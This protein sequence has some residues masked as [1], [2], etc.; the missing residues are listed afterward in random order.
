MLINISH[1]HR[2]KREWKSWKCLNVPNCLSFLSWNHIC[3]KLHGYIL[4][5]VSVFLRNVLRHS[6]LYTHAH[7]RHR[8]HIHHFLFLS[9]AWLE[10]LK[11]KNAHREKRL[12][13]C[14]TFAFMLRLCLQTQIHATSVMWD[15]G[16]ATLK[17]SIS[18]AALYYYVT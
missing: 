8:P 11:I 3:S 14:Q 4:R 10:N 5:Y 7:Y 1:T 6:L 16:E 9:R 15:R 17:K 18:N 2:K 12:R 13:C